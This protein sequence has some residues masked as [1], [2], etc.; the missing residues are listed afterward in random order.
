MRAINLLKN[1][2]AIDFKMLAKWL[3]IL[4]G[5]V[6]VAFIIVSLFWKSGSQ[7]DVLSACNNQFMKCA[8]LLYPPASYAEELDC[9]AGSVQ[10]DYSE[11]CPKYC[12]ANT[13]EEDLKTQK[14]AY[15]GPGTTKNKRD[16]FGHCCRGEFE[17]WEAGS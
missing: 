2:K 15:K 14:D 7:I 6:V 5:L 3:L 17:S 8:C 10:I 1:K 4:I 13:F 11:N 12:A 16:Y 9:P